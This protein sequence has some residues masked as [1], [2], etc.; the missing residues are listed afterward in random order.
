MTGRIEDAK[1][2]ALR[3]L[4][5]GAFATNIPTASASSSS[6]AGSTNAGIGGNQDGGEKPPRSEKTTFERLQSTY[7]QSVISM[8]GKS[9]YA[10]PPL[11]IS[12]SSTTDEKAA[13]RPPPSTSATAAAAAETKEKPPSWAAATA[14]QARRLTEREIARYGHHQARAAKGK[15]AKGAKYDKMCV[16]TVSLS[17]PPARSRATLQLTLPPPSPSPPARDPRLWFFWLPVLICFAVFFAV[18]HLPSLVGDAKRTAARVL[19]FRRLLA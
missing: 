9:Q 15:G 8:T 4:G 2:V 11:A 1:N 18:V 7:H 6:P 14:A 13:V 19:P 3:I 17:L 16:P 12:T 10:L 5:Q